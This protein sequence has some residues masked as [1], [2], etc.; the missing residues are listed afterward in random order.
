[1]QNRRN[2]RG[3]IA[4]G[5]MVAARP[6]RLREPGRASPFDRAES[7]S[8]TRRAEARTSIA[9]DPRGGRPLVGQIRLASWSPAG[10]EPSFWR[11]F[12]IASIRRSDSRI[13][14]R[15]S[16]DSSS[17]TAADGDGAGAVGFA[18][19]SSSPNTTASRCAR[20]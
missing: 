14:M 5:A 2:A 7:S 17:A 11:S 20:T 13:S 4:E 1:M 15:T 6:R 10:Q 18:A 8:A 16:V 19:P 9:D 3:A 12:V